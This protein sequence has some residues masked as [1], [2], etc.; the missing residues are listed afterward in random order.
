[1]PPARNRFRPHLGSLED[2][3]VP[4]FYPGLYPPTISD[5]P[6]MQAVA[7]RTTNPIPFV[8]LDIDINF[9]NSVVVTAAASDPVLFPPGSVAVLPY[10]LTRTFT[11]T[12][13]AGRT[14]TATVT[15]TATN[16]YGKSASDSF[17]VTVVRPPRV[18][19]S[20]DA[21]PAGAD[22]VVNVRSQEG[23]VRFSLTPF[24]ASF[25]GGANVAVGDVTGDAVDDVVVGAGVGGAPRVVVYDG[26]TGR[27][28]ADYF[29]FDQS[30]RGGVSV[31]AGDVTG[32]WAEDVIAGAGAGGGPH[33]RVFAA[34]GSELASFF[35]LDHAFTGGVSV[36]AGDVTGDEV[37]DVV[38]GA[39][40]GGGPVVRLFD[41][42]TGAFRASYL[43]GPADDRGGAKAVVRDLKADGSMEVVARV[44][45]KVRTFAPLTGDDLTAGFS[46][47]ELSR[48]FVD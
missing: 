31:A 24:E 42:R 45:G 19:L 15:L 26:L 14:G 9:S 44:A 12:P 32:D 11:L 40:A 6:D 4:I 13:A 8:V 43:V 21:V 2:R 36:A 10:F 16:S 23:S 34:G 3:T 48:V 30:F 37:A 7:G 41:G 38:V 46:A 1:M 18:R 47:D 28:V 35:A 22:P 29:A 25:R 27:V 20:A 5:V 39:G 17:V 33:V